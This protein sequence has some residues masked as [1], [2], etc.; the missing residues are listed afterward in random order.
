MNTSKPKSYRVVKKIDQ[1]A[2]II[3]LNFNTFFI[4]LFVTFIT[5]M[6]SA[7][8]GAVAF[9]V[10]LIIIVAIYFILYYIE[11]KL[12]PKRVSKLINN[13]YNPI[14]HIKITKSIKRLF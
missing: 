8:M 3:G 10:G 14:N 13:Y 5:I 1:E 9:G 7:N 4:F 6:A 2:K 12:G 11:G